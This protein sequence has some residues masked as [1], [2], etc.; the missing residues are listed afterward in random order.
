M[1]N[2]PFRI[3][4]VLFDFDGTL[5]KPGALNFP[6]LKETIGCPTDIPVL[7]FIEGLPVPEHRE[8]AIAVV[9]RFEKKAAAASEPNPGAEDLVEYLRSEGLAVGIL[10]RNSLQS[11]ERSLE[12]FK[13]LQYSDFNIIISRD[14]PVAPKPSADGIILAAQELNVEVGQIMM[15][16]DFVFDIQS[17]KDA[18]CLTAFLDYGTVPGNSHIESDFTVSGLEEIRRIVR[19]G[20][21]LPMGKLPNDILEDFL[22]QFDFD[23]PSVLIHPGVGEDTACVDVEKEEVLVLKSDPITFATDS[24]GHYAVLINANDIVT[25]GAVPRWFL[26]T[27]MFP[28]GVSAAEIWHVMDELKSMCDQWN[29]SLCGGHTEIT[30]A[31]TRPVVTGMLAGTVGKKDLIDKRNVRAGDKVILTKGIAVEGTSIIAREFGDKLI[32]LGMAV[33]EIEI[34][35]QFLSSISVID[36]AK[37]AARSAGVS[38]MHDI[39]EGGLS[40][41]LEE[42]SIA[43]AH[44][45]GIDVNKIPVFPLTKKICRLFDIDPRGLIGSGSLLICCRKKHTENLM[46]SISDAGIDV[47]CIGEVLEAGRGIEATS[48]GRPAEWPR[49]EVD[50]ISRLFS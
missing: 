31:V 18:G 21:P 38:A 46:A 13:K 10:T 26:T 35:R 41:A 29:I 39:T 30:D 3:K 23:D 33:S 22:N 28:C 40:N 6:L 45:I 16:G 1:I 19:L 17:G 25:S 49:F 44:R 32:Q 14:T 5:T 43:C 4:A 2:K 27:L 34:C 24:I 9:E 20:L 37:I 42:L 12:N 8:E 11:I 47:A 36:E 48:Q 7:E 50:E 15:I